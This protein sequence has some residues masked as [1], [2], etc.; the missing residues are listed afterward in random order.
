MTTTVV[1]TTSAIAK[2]S[3]SETLSFM[4]VREPTPTNALSGD[5]P[6]EDETLRRNKMQTTPHMPI[7]QVDELT[8]TAGDRVQ[9]DCGQVAKFVAIMGDQNAEGMGPAIDYSTQEL[10][11]NQATLPISAGGVMSQQ[12][13]V[14]SLRQNAI[15]QLSE[16]M[17]R[18]RWQRSLVH[19]AGARGKD[20]GVDWILQP[21]TAAG[22]SPLLAAQMVNPVLAPTFNR[23]YVVSAGTVIQGGQQL[24]SVLTTDLMRLS[25]VDEISAIIS[26]QR[27]RMRPVRIPGDTAALESP[28]KGVLYMDALVWDAFIT[29]PTAGNNIRTFQMNAL[30]RSEYS[31]T[32]KH[33]LF[34]GECMM[35]NDILLRKMNYPIRFDA[36]DSV[37][38]V[39]AANRLTAT[40][41][42]VTVAAGLSTTHQVARSIFLSAQALAFV[43]GGHRRSRETYELLE[44]NTDNFGRDLQ[45]AGAIMGAESKLRWAFPNSDGNLEPTDYGV[46]VIDS[47]VRKRAVS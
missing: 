34:S 13:T 37:A 4:A 10:L 36:G 20:D 21:N 41:S 14:H 11:L 12:R 29:D 44:K 27:I 46:M 22:P 39:T 9:V 24:A 25:V 31:S 2:K 32:G 16:A 38:I 5:M 19:M 28:I 43:S 6:R 3:W 15:F 26:E 33:P 1:G 42:N 40:E 45:F 17:P 18:F 30:K 35:W 7:M 8:K 47:V 23:H